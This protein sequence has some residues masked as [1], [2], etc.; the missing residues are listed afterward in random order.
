MKYLAALLVIFFALIGST[1]AAKEEALE[2]NGSSTV[3]AASPFINMRDSILSYF[4]P[5]EGKVVKIEDNLIKLDIGRKDKVRIVMRLSVY[6]QGAPFYHPITKQIIGRIEDH[7]GEVEVK[8]V[9]ENYALAVPVNGDIKVGDTVRI[10]STR[11]KIAYIQAVDADWATAEAFYQALKESNRFDIAEP[12]VKAYTDKALSDAGRSLGVKAVIVFSTEKNNGLLMQARLLWPEDEKTFAQVQGS[13]TRQQM[14][15]LSAG[16]EF[17]PFSRQELWESFDMPKGGLLI[18]FGDVKGDG[19]PLMIISN[20]NDIRIYNPK[21]EPTEIWD[22]KGVSS[23]EHLSIDALDI[24]GDG[25]DEIIVTSMKGGTISSYILELIAGHF[26]RIA[27][28]LPY[29][30]RVMDGRLLMQGF[31]R[32][33]GFYGPVYEAMWK[34]GIEKGKTLKLPP[35]TDIYGFNYID[36]KHVLTYDNDGFLYVY[37]NGAMVWKSK[38]PYGGFVYSFDKSYVVTATSG[39]N[40]WYV[41]GRIL[42]INTGRGKEFIVFKNVPFIGMLKGLGYKYAEFYGLTW[43]G[44]SMEEENI[45]KKIPGMV[46]DYWIEGKNLYFLSTPTLTM[47]LTKAIK[48]T[49][50]KGTTLYLY[51]TGY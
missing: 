9:F 40:K 13:L 30:F 21:N 31:S 29:F 3:Q 18:T 2:D 14:K 45:L 23:E 32:S 35:D 20:G 26:S 15:E 49:F 47:R 25:K 28:N 10:T 12:E 7:V 22:I 38:E 4:Y 46:T 19:K 17:L 6:R 33:D 42:S 16:E 11:I 50:M 39:S 5:V 36:K 51:K 34:N 43:N 8:Q 27:D 48:G 37:D 44:L 41:K 24:N 1:A